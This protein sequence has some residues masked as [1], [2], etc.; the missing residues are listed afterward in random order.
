MPGT[1]THYLLHVIYI[2]LRLIPDQSP[3]KT[4]ISIVGLRSSGE[5]PIH[6]RGWITPRGGLRLGTSFNSLGWTKGCDIS[7][8]TEQEAVEHELEGDQYLGY[9]TF[10]HNG[11]PLS[12]GIFEL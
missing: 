1:L 2:M 7:V 4:R 8:M 3:T 6:D 12:Y 9:Q 5:L 11:E 10:E